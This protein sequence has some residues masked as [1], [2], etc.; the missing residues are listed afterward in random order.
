MLNQKKLDNKLLGETL[1]TYSITSGSTNAGTIQLIGI[2][3]YYN[4]TF[5]FANGRIGIQNLTANT[6]PTIT[7]DV[8]EDMPTFNIEGGNA[9]RGSAGSTQPTDSGHITHTHGENKA[10]INFYNYIGQ[11]PA[12]YLEATF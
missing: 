11:A 7:I 6:R 5:A 10:Y 12:G 8:P 2:V 3:I 9:I 4:D 1:R